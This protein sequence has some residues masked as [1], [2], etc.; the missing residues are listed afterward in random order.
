MGFFLSRFALANCNFFLLPVKAP[1]IEVCHNSAKLS[2]KVHGVPESTRHAVLHFSLTAPFS[3]FCYS[4]RGTLQISDAPPP[5]MRRSYTAFYQQGS[6]ISWF[7]QRAKITHV[8]FSMQKVPSLS[9]FYSLTI[10][11]FLLK[12]MN[13]N[14]LCLMACLQTHL[15]SCFRYLMG[16]RVEHPQLVLWAYWVA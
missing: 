14:H 11:T 8:K 13:L 6:D 4:Y 10:S 1:S 7:R 15:P 16:T 3:C 9:S 5:L 12:R 2:S